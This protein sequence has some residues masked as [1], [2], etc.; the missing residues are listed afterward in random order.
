MGASVSTVY[1][2]LKLKHP[3]FGH[4]ADRL[5]PGHAHPAYANAWD[6][7]W[8]HFQCCFPGLAGHGSPHNPF[9]RFV[10]LY[11]WYRENF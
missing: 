4:S 7:H 11:P 8:C 10:L 3:K 1:Y 5:R 6:Q 9:P 2:N